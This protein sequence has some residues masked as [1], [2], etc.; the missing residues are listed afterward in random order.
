MRDGRQI[1]LYSGFFDM[2]LKIACYRQFN[3]GWQQNFGGFD[4]NIFRR[5]PTVLLS[6]LV[7][8]PFAVAGEMALRAY[9][10][11]RTFPS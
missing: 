3:S 9:R 11:D 1:A 4:Y 10:A 8:S 5:V 6:F 7:S 2:G